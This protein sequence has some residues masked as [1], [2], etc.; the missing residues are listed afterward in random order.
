MKTIMNPKERTMLTKYL[1]QREL[2]INIKRKD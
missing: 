1:S 2:M